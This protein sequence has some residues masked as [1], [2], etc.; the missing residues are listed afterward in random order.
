MIFCYGLILEVWLEAW[1]V[2]KLG[3][4]CGGAEVMGVLTVELSRRNSGHWVLP[5]GR[6]NTGL[7]EG[8]VP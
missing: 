2:V 1:C 5:S 8:L 6:I 4:Q 7:C 3:V